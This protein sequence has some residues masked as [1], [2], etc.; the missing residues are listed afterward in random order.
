MASKQRREQAL[1][2]MGLMP[3]R[4]LSAIEA[5]EDRRIDALHKKSASFSSSDNTHST[6]DAND[7]A[8]AWRI[9]NSRW[10]SES[11]PNLDTLED[12]MTKGSQLCPVRIAKF[13]PNF[14]SI[15]SA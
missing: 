2:A 1:R 12:P 14:L 11:L 6:S 8:Y 4:D 9:R 15:F 3:V 13:T 10:L 7:I 5:E